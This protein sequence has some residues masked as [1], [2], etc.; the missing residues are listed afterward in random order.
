L[1]VAQN[2]L[3]HAAEVVLDLGELPCVPYTVRDINQVLLN[4]LVNAAQAIE[5]QEQ[6]ESDGMIRI[7]TYATDDAV[8]LEISD[9]GPGIESVA[10]G[11]VFDPFFTTKPPGK[12]TG[13]GLSISYDIITNKHNGQ[14][15]VDST[16]GEGTTFTIKLP[17]VSP[18]NETEHP[19]DTEPLVNEEN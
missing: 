17:M 2:E 9:N 13:L 15:L 5:Y 6:R 1:I 18:A 3:K 4:I 14:L 16:L 12:G 8:V 11:K 10:L 7:R 19:A